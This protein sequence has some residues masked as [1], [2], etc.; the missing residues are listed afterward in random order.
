MMLRIVRTGFRRRHSVTLAAVES[1]VDL[2]RFGSKRAVPQLVEDVMRIERA[3]VIAD[4]GMV[5]PNDKVR[6]T[7][8]LADERMEQRLSR[9]CITHFDGIARLDDGPR[10]EVIIDHRLDRPGANISWNIA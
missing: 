4:P 1:D 6:A 3:I 7:E 10:A 9:T 5:A 2:Q 8:I